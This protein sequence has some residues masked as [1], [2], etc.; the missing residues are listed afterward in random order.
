MG[1]HRRPDSDLFHPD[2]LWDFDNDEPEE[3]QRGY[4]TADEQHDRDRV[5]E[6]QVGAR[7]GWTRPGAGHWAWHG[8]LYDED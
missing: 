2:W 6:F 3:T 5:P 4:A 1:A 8:D 7:A